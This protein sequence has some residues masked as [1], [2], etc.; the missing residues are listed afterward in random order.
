MIDIKLARRIHRK[1]LI[2]CEFIFLSIYR[3]ITHCGDSGMTNRIV[4]IIKRTEGNECHYIS[5]VS[6]RYHRSTITV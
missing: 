6:Q 4:I 5:S 2:Y 1:Q 3:E